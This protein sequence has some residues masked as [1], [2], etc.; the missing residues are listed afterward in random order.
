LELVEILFGF[1]E[2]FICRFHKF[3]LT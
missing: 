1:Y 3:G 2:A